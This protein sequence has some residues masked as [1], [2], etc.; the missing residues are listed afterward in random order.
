MD[1]AGAALGQ[2]AAELRPVEVELAAEDIEEWRVGGGIDEVPPSVHGHLQLAR[3]DRIPS[4]G[5]MTDE[6][7]PRLG[8]PRQREAG[9]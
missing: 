4:P 1:G 8:A 2:A 7:V 9:G 6:V 5:G 3:H